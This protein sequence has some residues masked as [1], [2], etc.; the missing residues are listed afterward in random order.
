V[1]PPSYIIITPVRNERE[2]LPRTIESMVAQTV[3]PA[4]WVLVDDGS[5]DGTAGIVDEAAARHPWITAVHREDRG[6]RLPG[7]GVVDAFYDGL[8]RVG[9]PCFDFLVKFDADLAFEP[10]YF[11]SCF[12]RFARHPRLGIGG[13]AVC[14]RQA[15][16][17]VIESA[18]DPAFHVRGATK[19]YRRACW[20]ELGGLIRAPGWDTVD[21]LTANMLGWETMTFPELR[22]HQLKATGSAD[23]RW[24]NWV[25]NGVANYNTGYHP[26]FMAAKC[27]RRL[28]RP[29][30]GLGGA[31][32]AW[33]FFKA[34]VMRAP[35]P[36]E[37]ELVAYVRRQQ[38]NRLRGE[39]S[40]WDAPSVGAAAR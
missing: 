3:R 36:V 29:P 40:V 21:E 23:G 16:G 7:T 14:G 22:V 17:L 30:Y 6:H 28:F 15:D 20:D 31:G 12:R 33:G 39:A 34:W 1:V 26:L 11:E 25:K 37:P 18:G 32:L 5:G 4:L 2:N 8:A 13:G 38:M 27:A 9:D 24:R 19:I 35:R 10:D